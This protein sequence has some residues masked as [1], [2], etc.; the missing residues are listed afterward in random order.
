MGCI[1]IQYASVSAVYWY[2][3]LVLVFRPEYK[4]SNSH[5]TIHYQQSLSEAYRTFWSPPAQLALRQKYPTV[6]RESRPALQGTTQ[7]TCWPVRGDV[8]NR[9]AELSPNSI[10]H[11]STSSMGLLH[12]LVN[13]AIKMQQLLLCIS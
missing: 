2:T 6:Q 8:S 11:S 9:V 10:E 5:M 7:V 1:F 4:V 3:H 12:D 13:L